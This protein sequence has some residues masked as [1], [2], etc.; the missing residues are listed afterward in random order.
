MEQQGESWRPWDEDQVF[1][2]PEREDWIFWVT[3]MGSE[4]AEEIAATREWG[5]GNAAV[6]GA[7]RA[8]DQDAVEDRDGNAWGAGVWLPA[9]HDHE[10]RA[11][12]LIRTFPDRGNGTK[13]YRKFRKQAARVPQVPGV[14]ISSYDVDEG[15]VDFGPFIV[16]AID[17]VNAAGEVQIYWIVT[18]FS[19]GKDEVVR[20][21]FQSVYAHL[22]DDIEV[23]LGDLISHAYYGVKPGSALS[24]ELGLE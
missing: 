21:E 5:V 17:T 13:A 20:L 18:F 8:M 11:G 23:E 6:I 2:F 16:Q 10:A 4:G 7:I 3:G 9:E 14:T 19:E 22:V 1:T 24:K 12:V 15:E